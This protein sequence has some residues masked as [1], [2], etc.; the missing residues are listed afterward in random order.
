MEIELAESDSYA[1]RKVVP[2][3]VFQ[4]RSFVDRQ[5]VSESW[6]ALHRRREEMTRDENKEIEFHDTGKVYSAANIS[7]R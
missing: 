7:L 3:T 5:F 4:I 1:F 6:Y 2:Q